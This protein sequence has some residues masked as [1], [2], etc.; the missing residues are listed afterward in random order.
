MRVVAFVPNYPPHSRVGAW[1]ATHA[2]LAHLVRLGHH[3]EVFTQAQGLLEVVDGVTVG[4]GHNPVVV[5]T[6]LSSCD[7]VVYH[8]GDLTGRGPSLAERWGKPHVVMAHG[9][10]GD[11]TAL[12]NAALVVFNSHSLA[13]A[14][15]P[16]GDFSF[17]WIVCRP[18]V[19]AGAYRTT[20]GDRV[21]LVNLSES[22]GGELFWRLVRG[23][24]HRQ[25]LGVEGAYGNQYIDTAAN[26]ET[27]STTV[28]MRDDVYRRTRILLMPSERETWG[29][30][31]VEAMASG[32][33]TIAHPT[34]GLIE[35]LGAAG[36]FV[37]RDDVHRWLA[38]IERLHDS[39]EWRH[40]STRS[41][42]RSV[43]LD[44]ADDLE[45]FAKHL[46][47]I[48]TG[49]LADLVSTAREVPA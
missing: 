48:H 7:I 28:N 4:S 29:M 31:A 30:T 20:P 41:L 14:S 44:P 40:A 21:T 8:A 2:Y 32:I 43:E 33:P 19:D 17:P 3:V 36:I 16:I 12:E 35:S 5:D 6:A 39:E 9:E 13:R 11:P 1:A 10:I 42:A 23:A 18:P 38:E 25:F 26:A 47:F 46:L 27:I 34:A 22:K 49:R 45:R 24:P 15:V 37:D